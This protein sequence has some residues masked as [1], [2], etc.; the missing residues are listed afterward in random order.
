VAKPRPAGLDRPTG[1]RGCPSSG[2]RV[3]LPPY[4]THTLAR[5]RDQPG[6]PWPT[7]PPRKTGSSCARADGGYF[8]AV[9]RRAHRRPAPGAGRC[10]FLVE[11]EGLNRRGAPVCHGVFVVG[12]R[13]LFFFRSTEY[14]EVPERISRRATMLFHGLERF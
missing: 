3:S 14:Q 2:G 9:D 13:P 10:L 5:P 7:R 1:V 6:L 4:G 8:G 12:F 11:V